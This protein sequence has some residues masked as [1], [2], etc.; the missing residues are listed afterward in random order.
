MNEEKNIQGY[1]HNKATILRTMNK[2]GPNQE[3][4]FLVTHE[5]KYYIF[6][7]KMKAFARVRWRWFWHLIPQHCCIKNESLLHVQFC[8]EL[9]I[10]FKFPLQNFMHHV[11]FQFPSKQFTNIFV[12]MFEAT[13]FVKFSNRMKSIN[14]TISMIKSWKFHVFYQSCP[15]LVCVSFHVLVKH[16]GGLGSYTFAHHKIQCKLFGAW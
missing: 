15:L 12:Q 16:L 3:I 13:S 5:T 1:N 6:I 2:W 10:V 14:S 4:G 7:L 9:C 11:C 8:F